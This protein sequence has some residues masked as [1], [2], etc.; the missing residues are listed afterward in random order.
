MS[1][2]FK[3]NDKSGENMIRVGAA[4]T[5]NF[6]H[7]QLC[8]KPHVRSWIIMM[9]VLHHKV[10]GTWSLVT[11]PSSVGMPQHYTLVSMNLL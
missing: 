10:W 8:Q 6:I 2:E 3:K 11:M 4:P 9:L 5:I 7:A 1:S